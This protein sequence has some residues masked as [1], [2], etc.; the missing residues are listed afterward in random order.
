ML[1]RLAFVTLF[2]AAAVACKQGEGE[3]CQ[4]DNDCES[5]LVCAALTD[6]CEK[7]A[8]G[9]ERDAGPPDAEPPI[10]GPPVD[11]EPVDAGMPDAAPP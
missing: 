11:A 5:G 4:V 6:T 3:R 7:S 8:V 10:D 9:P 2:A 1:R